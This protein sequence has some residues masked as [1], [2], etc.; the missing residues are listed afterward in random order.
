MLKDR[1]SKLK[2]YGPKKEKSLNRLGVVTIE[3]LIEYYPRGYENRDNPLDMDNFDSDKKYYIQARV[4]KILDNGPYSNNFKLRVK[5]NNRIINVMFFNNKKYYVNKFSIG[6]EYFFYGKFSREY[7]QMIHPEFVKCDDKKAADFFGILPLY[8]LTEGISNNDVIKGVKQ[9]LDNIVPESLPKGTIERNRLL[10][11]KEA[12]K[13]IHFPKS[14]Q[15]FKAAK[16]RIIF[17]EFLRLHMGLMLINKSSDVKEATEFQYIQEIDKY[18]DMLPFQLTD[19]QMKVKEEIFSDMCS[20]KSMNRLLQGDVGSGKTIVAFLSMILSVLNGYQAVMMVPTE[21]LAVQHYESFMELFGKSFEVALLTSSSKKKKQ[22]YEEIKRGEIKIV[23]GT[24]ALIQDDLE[25]HNLGYVVTDEQHRFGVKQRKNL[26]EKG[27]APDILIMSATPI[28]RTLSLVLYSDVDISTIDTLP[29]GRKKIV[30]S[31]VNNKNLENMYKLIYDQI[32]F[33]RQCYFVYPLIEDSELVDMKS[34]EQGY[35]ELKESILKEFNIEMLHGKMKN[36]EKTEVMGRF[37]RKETDI[38]VSTTVIE[39]GVN[40]PN[41]TV[42]V[43][44]NTDRFGLAQLH[45]LRGRVGRSEFQSYCFLLSESSSKISKERIKT[46]VNTNDGFVIAQK[47]LEL[48]GPGDIVGL[49]QHGVPDMKM[50]DLFKHR[51]ILLKAKEEAEYVMENNEV[52]DLS[53]VVDKFYQE[54]S[55]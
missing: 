47:D 13:N 27:R 55:I 37:S 1:I 2:G 51:E 3:D 53:G 41:A 43:I 7:N 6:D 49:R 10:D 17:E 38:L 5:W 34:L 29:K 25:F 9:A 32:R 18:I 19:S 31:Y 50:G 14:P 39:V 42:M 45:Q 24:H 52:G 33:G 15:Q 40:V 36:D 46:M 30:T 8:P 20:L 54:F 28:P 22:I 16:Y 35:K 21:V 26:V 48:R 4:E 23:I 12:L 11:R 44:E